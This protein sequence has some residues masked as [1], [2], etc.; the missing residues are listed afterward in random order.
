MDTS[1][2][3]ESI[4]KLID[5]VLAEN[6]ALPEFQRDFVWETWQTHDLFDSLVKDIFIGSLIYGVPSF[7]L[8]VRSVDV[9][10]RKGLGSRGK[11][12]KTKFSERE[13]KKMAQIRGFR[14]LLDGQQRVT[15]IFR[16]LRGPDEVW[17]IFKDDTE[18]DPTVQNKL[19]NERSLEDVVF[20]VVGKQDPTRLSILLQDVYS[21]M[22]GMILRDD[23]RAAVLAKT[24]FCKGR[25]IA[26]LK[27]DYLFDCFLHYAKKL[28]DL[29]K[30]EKIISYYLLDTDVE[31]FALFF[32]RSNSRG[33]QLNFIDILAAK[34]YGGF[35]LRDELEKFEDENKGSYHLIR[36]IVVRTVSLIASGGV[37]ASR[38]Y[39]L[40]HLTAKHFQENWGQICKHYKDAIDF[41]YDNFFLISQEWMPYENM[42]IPL[43]MMLRELPNGDVAEISELQARVLKAWYWGAVFSGRYGVT[44]NDMIIDDAKMLVALAKGDVK[45]LPDY[46]TKLLSQL[47]ITEHKDFREVWK[48]NSAL[49]KGTLGLINHASKGLLNWENATR[50]QLNSR[51]EDHHIFPKDYLRQADKEIED[52]EVDCV[53]NRTLIPKIPNI[54]YSNRAPSDYLADVVQKNPKL[55][56][57]LLTHLVPGDLLNGAYDDLYDVFLDDRAKLVFDAFC[58]QVRDPIV[59]I[60][61]KLKTSG[62]TS[63][64]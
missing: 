52:Q 17:V 4:K 8:T 64:N 58:Q 27:A 43:M 21:L 41:L 28:E 7:E 29:L 59:G 48:K 56:E 51:L 47:Q 31:K 34:L 9:R 35:N 55:I 25:S 22:E 60:I 46:L 54:K 3:T 16:A 20:S 13:I 12:K 50:L 57:T 37:D 32:E 33:I 62:A 45:T 5:D 24:D 19:L 10:P 2:K 11:L 63:V 14:L 18:L 23:D 49:Y 42:L 30:S 61:A 26:E 1:T 40:K 39:I 44:A 15:S 38:T 53:L 6:V 36:E